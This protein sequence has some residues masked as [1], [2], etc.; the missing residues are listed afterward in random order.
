MKDIDVVVGGHSNG[1]FHRQGRGKLFELPEAVQLRNLW[2]FEERITHSCELKTY[3]YIYKVLE[4]CING[5]GYLKSLGISQKQRRIVGRSRRYRSQNAIGLPE[6]G[7]CV[8]Q[9]ILK[10]ERAISE[11]QDISTKNVLFTKR[12]VN[13]RR[14]R[15]LPDWVTTW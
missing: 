9:H 2:S 12:N 5:M 4:D 1:L 13:C 8:L 3:G 15:E 7:A 11:K 10:C 14:I 6:N